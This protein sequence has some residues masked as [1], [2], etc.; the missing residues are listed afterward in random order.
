MTNKETLETAMEQSA[1]DLNC[2]YDD[3]LKSENITVVSKENTD[4]RKYLQLPFDCQL[5]SYGNNV[6]AS[7]SE[8]LIETVKNY[9]DKY[10]TYCCFETP[11]IND[12]GEE[13]KKHG[14]KI[15][16]MAEYFLYDAEQPHGSEQYAEGFEY[17]ILTKDDLCD[18]YLPEWSNALCEK[19]KELDKI[20]V[21]AYYNNELVGLAGASADCEKMWQIGIDVLPEYRKRGIANT[22][23]SML[24]KEIL[25]LGK[26]P[27]YCAAWSNIASVRN[28]LKSGFYPTWVELTAKSAEFADDM[29]K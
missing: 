21:G 12:L 29:L 20:A 25:K 7:V 5:V 23:T 15:C 2:K 8:D 4:A 14:L 26:V 18:L 6:V 16:F 28:A 9:I 13:L 3:F 24:A 27:F 19:R 17:K 11:F 1:V 22:V 10:P